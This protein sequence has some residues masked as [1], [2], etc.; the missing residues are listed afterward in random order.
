MNLPRQ[1]RFFSGESGSC[2]AVRMTRSTLSEAACC[3]FAERS[4]LTEPGR[5]GRSPSSFGVARTRRGDW[6]AGRL[7]SI[8]CRQ[9]VA[10]RGISGP[11]PGRVRRPSSKSAS[12][13]AGLR[14]PDQ[15]TPCGV[16]QVERTRYLALSAELPSS[17]PGSTASKSGSRSWGQPGSPT[18][19]SSERWCCSRRSEARENGSAPSMCVSCKLSGELAESPGTALGDKSCGSRKPF[20]EPAASQLS[21][22]RFC[23]T[24]RDRPRRCG[25]ESPEPAE[26]VPERGTGSSSRRGS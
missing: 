23:A 2:R 9:I 14:E 25:S 13:D 17:E 11:E 6:F 7:S 24:L 20:R 16:Q 18:T 10:C 19:P 8:R 5:I 4:S 26:S 3:G 1:P 15:Q 22:P 12:A 21:A